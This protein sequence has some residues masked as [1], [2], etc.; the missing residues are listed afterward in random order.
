MPDHDPA[1]EE[2]ELYIR[3][4]ITTTRATLYSCLLVSLTLTIA[5]GPA[6]PPSGS[7]SG[8]VTY[9][10]QP[11]TAGVVT[12]INEATGVG[13]SVKLDSSGGY[14]IQTIRT[15]QYKVAVHNVPPPPGGKVVMLNI[16]EKFQDIQSSGLSV[17]VEEGKNTSDLKL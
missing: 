12:L 5:C 13:G 9:N 7:V 4:F 15:G 3:Q 10:G 14:Y 2:F 16:P 11:L 6:E 17:T 8:K 1:Y